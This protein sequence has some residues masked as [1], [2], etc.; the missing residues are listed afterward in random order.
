MAKSA[1]TKTKV[2]TA[3]SA[4]LRKKKADMQAE[5]GKSKNTKNVYKG[6]YD[7]GVRIL[8]D[9]VKE[10]KAREKKNPGCLTDGIDNNLLA[11][12]FTGPPNKHSVYAVEMYLTQKCVVEDLG[13]STADGIHGA[14]A[15]Y[16]DKLPGGQYNGPYSYDEDTG[17]VHGNPARAPEVL[18]FLKCVKNKA[19]VKGAAATRH[20]AEATTIEDMRLLMQWSESECSHKKLESLKFANS[21]DLLLQIKHGL[22][23][24]FL[25]S[26]FVL[27]TRNFETCQIQ[28]RDLS[29]GTGP[30]PYYLPYLGVFL[31]N[32][33]GWQ[34]KQGYDGP[35][36]SNHYQIYEQEDT[37]EID[38]FTHL[39]RWR[40]LYRHLLGRDFE[41]D[42]YL[43]PFVSSN[44]TIHAKKPMTHETAQD[45]LNEFTLGAKIDKTFTTHCLR[46]GGAQYRFMFAPIGKRWSLSIIRWWGGWAVG[47]QVDTLMRYL[48]DS[49]QSYETGHGDALYPF[50]TEPDKS[51]MGEHKALQ[52]PSTAEFRLFGAQILTKLDSIRASVSSDMARITV[53][54]SSCVNHIPA[55]FHGQH[56]HS[57]HASPEVSRPQPTV[58]QPSSFTSSV[59]DENSDPNSVVP[60]S[61]AIIPGV[62]R[63]SQSWK[64]AID[65]WF[66]GDPDH[67]LQVAL[68]DWPAS[69]YSGKMRLVTGTLYSNRKLLAEEYE[70]LGCNDEEFMQNYPEYPKITLLLNA[71]RQSKGLVRKGNS[72]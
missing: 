3:D 37:P 36:E 14:M 67:G 65:Q 12:A 63:D 16:W 4:S 57:H 9:V 62:G 19:R 72:A 52:P 61:G 47:E 2:A 28:E 25:S 38:M 60:V 8:Q 7:R 59:S 54:T 31:D 68:K 23:R 41:P 22:M 39:R 1:R 26:G 53:A 20:H 50:R 35:L 6:Y 64:R 33:K 51:F 17:K 30:A 44:G 21:Q 45:L 58:T 27:W 70:R 42:D 32:R 49:L 48:L 46:R 40:I 13:K 29:N 15:D 11:K 24:A 69:W 55:Q 34:K 66:K 56:T 18:D 10:R 5:F 71:I 43:F